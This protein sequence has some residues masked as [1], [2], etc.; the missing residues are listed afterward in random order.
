MKK[1]KFKKMLFCMVM[2]LG[3]LSTMLIASV[4]A[5]DDD[6]MTAITIK[7]DGVEKEVSL[8]VKEFRELSEK[9]PSYTYSGYN[10]WPSLQVF[11]NA[12]GVTLETLL[13]M[14]G[15]K[16][17]A[18]M[19]IFR[20]SKGAYSNF[21]K[22]QLLDD[23][24]YYFPDGDTGDLSEWP[25]QRTE[26]GK[27]PVKAMISLSC[28]RSSSL[29]DDS[30]MELYGKLLYGQRCPIEPTACKSEQIEGLLPESTIIVSTE[31][32]PKWDAPDAYPGS[33]TVIPG[34]KV[35]LQ[36]GDGTPYGAIVHYTLDGSEPTVKSPI[37]NISYPTFQPHLNA[38]IPITGKMTIK[39]RTIGSGKADSDVVTYEY[40]LGSLACT[41]KG[42]GLTEPVYYALETLKAMTPVTASYQC[43]EGGQAV[44]L[45]G[46]GV[47]L[48]S[49]LNQLSASGRWM[50]KFVS[51]TGEE[52]DG[53]TVQDIKDKLCML[54]YE[55]N[56]SAVEDV[57][58][59]TTT[60]IQIL[61]N[62]GSVLK[63][64]DTIKLV[65]VDDEITISSVKLLD[66]TGQAVTSVAPGGGYCIEADF[67]NAVDAAE[68]ALLVFRVRSGEGTA[69]YAGGKTIGYAAVRTQVAVSGGKACAEFIMPS[70]L[71]GKAY[72]D[73][74]ALDSESSGVSLGKDNHD[75]SFDIE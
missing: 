12:K 55:V 74:L 62:Q 60:Y 64:I 14:A 16:E 52:Y 71:S 70:D 58:G 33:G 69:A 56:G 61:C 44:S 3:I 32:P 50:V 6:N 68:D 43:A 7:G 31:T 13:E 59:D 20:D 25:P 10:H 38:P 72:V 75:L 27:V 5:Q 2:V 36:H 40:D 41:I 19:I 17:N 35:I 48:G 49:L 42:A 29:E 8:T 37:Y 28:E 34:T 51:V 53:G 67:I 4:Q 45:N 39:A 1:L 22:Q 9:E 65:N 15:I 26:E 18:T 24:R 57:S 30:R 63:N 23:E 73:V 66:V 21:T 11:K 54:A 46:K 47:L